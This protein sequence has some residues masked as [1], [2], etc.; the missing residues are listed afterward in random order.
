MGVILAIAGLVLIGTA[1]LQAADA[2]GRIEVRSYP[3][4]KS[5]S[6]ALKWAYVCYLAIMGVGAIIMGAVVRW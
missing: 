4:L 1:T 5:Q 3:F 2:L 6:S